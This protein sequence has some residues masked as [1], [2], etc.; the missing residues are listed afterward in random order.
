MSE[1]TNTVE[2][3]TATIAGHLFGFPIARVQ[4]VFLP[5]RLTR[6]PLAGPEIAGILNVRGRVV[7]LVD[8]WRRLDFHGEA[9]NSRASI[10]V[11][12]EQ[13]GESYGLLVDAVGEVLQLP[14]ATREDAPINL[15]GRL[16]RVCSGVHRLQRGLLIVV[17]INRVL[18]LGA[19]VVPQS[20]TFA[21]AGPVEA[22]MQH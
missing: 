21:P 19:A 4:E 20:T 12:I 1:Q 8:M 10:A 7:T 3:V 5:D 11:A 14:V 22:Q 15:D 9:D 2:Y 17:D 13:N 16:A 18:D 6:V